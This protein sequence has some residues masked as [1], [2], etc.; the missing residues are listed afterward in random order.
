ME[1]IIGIVGVTG[2]LTISVAILS[3]IRGWVLSILWGWF[4][5]PLFGLPLLDIPHAIGVVLVV[6][7]LTMSQ[8]SDKDKEKRTKYNISVLLSPFLTLFI[9]WVVTWFIGGS[10]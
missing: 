8:K 6:G 5:A 2:F 1:A 9:G 4:V 7:F 10:Q 3:C